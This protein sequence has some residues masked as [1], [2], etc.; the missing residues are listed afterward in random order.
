MKVCVIPA[1]GGSRRIPGKNIREFHGRPIIAWSIGT[2][3][4][5][6]CF[7]RV[8]VSTDDQRIAEVARAYGAEV[9]FLRPA[10]IADGYTGTLQVIQHAIDW[11]D[12]HG[13]AS[14]IVCQLLATAPFVTVD[15][16]RSGLNCLAG[17]DADYSLAVC[18]F[19]FPIQ[20]A[21]RIGQNGRLAMFQPDCYEARS[22]D[23]ET[24]YHDAGQFCFGRRDAWLRGLCP[25]GAGTVPVLLPSHRVHD[26]D[27]IEDWKRAEIMFEAL[28]LSS[29]GKDGRDL[30]GEL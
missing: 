16:L 9:P 3:L 20:R 26:I 30:T 17:A 15:D 27:T 5:S 14:W 12:E 2:A 19:G 4:N 25:F 6:G 18:G 1:R 23:L 11:L 28:K 8:V 13:A 7:D 10:C 22:Q 29:E 21:V 24:A